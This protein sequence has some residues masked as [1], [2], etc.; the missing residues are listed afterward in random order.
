MR[1]IRWV[2]LVFLAAL[3]GACSPSGGSI[4]FNY[5]GQWQG[6]IQD[7]FA[8]T[9][10][11]TATLTQSGN[12]LAGTW[13]A[14]FIDGTNGGSA[15]GVVNGNQVVIELWPSNV[16]LCPYNVVANRS[17]STISGNYAAFDCTASITGTLQLTKQ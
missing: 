3:L 16:L 12:N 2:A 15:V 8:G 9:G 13:Q 6:P 7:S 17:G 11:V 10:S 4:G 14:S 5:S 1:F